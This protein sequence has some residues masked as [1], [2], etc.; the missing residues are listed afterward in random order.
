MNVH[1]HDNVFPLPVKTVVFF[2]TVIWKLDFCDLFVIYGF[3]SLI[4][5]TI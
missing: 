3:F 5:I 2:S 1:I 4:E